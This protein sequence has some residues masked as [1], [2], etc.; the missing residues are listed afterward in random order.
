MAVMHW[1]KLR[2]LVKLLKVYLGF[3]IIVCV[4]QKLHTWEM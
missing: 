1:S 3:R 2:G 4:A